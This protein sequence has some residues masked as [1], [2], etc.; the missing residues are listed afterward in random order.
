MPIIIV[1]MRLYAKLQ[2]I[3]HTMDYIL[4]SILSFFPDN[5]NPNAS[6]QTFADEPPPDPHRDI[7]V[8]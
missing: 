6:G 3:R 5:W 2:N 4:F 8:N 1:K 7:R